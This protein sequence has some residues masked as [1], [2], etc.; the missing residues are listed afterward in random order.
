MRDINQGAAQLDLTRLDG[1]GRRRWSRRIPTVRRPCRVTARN[2][3]DGVAVGQ[4]PLDLSLGGCALAWKSMP[5]ARG[6]QCMVEFQLPVATVLLSATVQGN[7][8][9][10][11]RPVLAKTLAHRAVFWPNKLSAASAPSD[12]SSCASWGAF[13]DG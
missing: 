2:L 4:V 6:T 12:C 3:G 9:F 8:I 13:A 7:R 10:T 1:N 5:P 11:S